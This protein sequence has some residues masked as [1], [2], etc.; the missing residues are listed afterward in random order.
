MANSMYANDT[1]AS[2]SGGGGSTAAASTGITAIM[3]FKASQA[4]AK[5]AKLTAEYNAKIRENE[6]ILLQRQARDEQERL[7]EGSEKLVSAQR[8]AAAKSGV[9]VAAVATRFMVTLNRPVALS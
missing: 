1:Q 7:R 2:T 4:A 5:N 8:V 9:V 6:R 3:G